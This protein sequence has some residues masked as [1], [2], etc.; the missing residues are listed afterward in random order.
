MFKSFAELV[1][2]ALHSNTI[3]V[4]ISA[5]VGSKK[6]IAELRSEMEAT[7]VRVIKKHS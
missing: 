7:A 3:N 6:M 1:Q 4:S 2:D 5:D